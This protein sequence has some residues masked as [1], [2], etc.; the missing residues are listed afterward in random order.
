M[1]KKQEANL[2]LCEKLILYEEEFKYYTDKLVETKELPYFNI[3]KVAE[4]TCKINE[5]NGKVHIVMDEMLTNYKHTGLY[6]G[7]RDE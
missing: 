5:F 7:K 2:N 3:I 6:C 4:Y 1:D